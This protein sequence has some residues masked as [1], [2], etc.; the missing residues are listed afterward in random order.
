MFT[1]HFLFFFHLVLSSPSS[2]SASCF[3]FCFFTFILLYSLTFSSGFDSFFLFCWPWLL[4]FSFLLFFSHL[5]TWKETLILF[6]SP[7]LFIFFLSFYSRFY[8]A[9]WLFFC[10]S[11]TL[12][13]FIPYVQLSISTFSRNSLHPDSI[14]LFAPSPFHSVF[15]RLS[16]TPFPT[17]FLPPAH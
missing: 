7:V 2:A 10:F 13:Y 3:L 1:F 11:A 5:Q 8:S 16:N 4:L 9:L 17:L 6:P 15:P 14:Y 12:V